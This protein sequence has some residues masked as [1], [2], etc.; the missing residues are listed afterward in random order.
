MIS[1]SEYG[2]VRGSERPGIP[3]SGSAASA[4]VEFL[5]Q[6]KTS[7]WEVG[8]HIGVERGLVVVGFTLLSCPEAAQCTCHCLPAMP[9][10]YCY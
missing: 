5:G 2:S 10:S 9:P 1:R 6:L 3:G 4:G 8:G 7:P